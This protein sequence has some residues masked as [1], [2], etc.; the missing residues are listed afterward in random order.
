MK[1]TKDE[2]IAA[3]VNDYFD[4]E[5][6]IIN[7]NNVTYS[8]KI[9]LHNKPVEPGILNG[10]PKK[11]FGDPS[12]NDILMAIKARV[13]IENFADSSI[14]RNL[15]KHCAELALKIGPDEFLRRL[16]FLLSDSFTRKNCNRIKYIYNSI[17]GWIEPKPNII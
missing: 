8:Q 5:E 17:K 13:G 3:V 10:R 11:Q 6:F 16:D 7:L 12:V 9:K 4:D 1:P 15:A 14:E 2:I